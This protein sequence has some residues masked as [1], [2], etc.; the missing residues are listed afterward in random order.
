MI[1]ISYKKYRIKVKPAPEYELLNIPYIQN[2]P[3]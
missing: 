2:D 3:E 1:Y